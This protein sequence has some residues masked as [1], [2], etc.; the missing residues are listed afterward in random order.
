MLYGLWQ[1]LQWHTTLVGYAN[2]EMSNFN[3]I[4]LF[5][6]VC[7]WMLICKNLLRAI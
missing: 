5:K 1:T 3:P 4:F 6:G 7:E 2:I